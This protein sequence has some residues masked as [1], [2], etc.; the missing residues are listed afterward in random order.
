MWTLTPICVR[1]LHAAF[2]KVLRSLCERGLPIFVTFPKFMPLSFSGYFL[3]KLWVIKQL[4]ILHCVGGKKV[5][6]SFFLL[7]RKANGTCGREWECS[8]CTQATWINLHS[9]LRARVQFGYFFKKASITDNGFQ[10]GLPYPLTR[11]G[12]H[13]A[14]RK[15]HTQKMEHIVVTSTLTA[16]FTCRQP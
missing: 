13:R 5:F 11:G 1:C 14:P 7:W 16:Y 12:G 4:Y 6:G 15:R 2:C 3:L 9:N 8:H 10:L